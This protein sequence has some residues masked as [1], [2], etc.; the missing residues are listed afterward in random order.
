MCGIVGIFNTNGAPVSPAILRKMTDVMSHRGPDGEGFYVDSFVGLAHRRLA[1]L[2]L[3]SAG[4]QPM[5]TE[6]GSISISY[7]GEVYNFREIRAELEALGY[8]FRSNTDTEVVLNA[9]HKWG[10]E[11]VARFNGIFA[12]TTWDKRTQTLTLIRDRYGTKPLY[13]YQCGDTFLFASEI[14]SFLHYP[15][16]KVELD[17]EALFEYFTFQNIFTDRTLFKGVKVLR[18]GHILQISLGN[19]DIS[20]EEYWDFDF[21][22]VDDPPSFEEGVEELNRLFCQAVQRQLVSDVEIGS[23]L[24]GGIDSGAITAIA[25]NN[26][27]Y[28]K[29]FCIGFDLS[30]ASGLELGFDE[31]EKAEMISA[32][33]K[34]EHYEMVLKSGDMERCME[35]LVWYLEDPRVGQSYPNFY[36]AKLAGKFVKVVLAG[37]GGDELFG[38]YPWR[39]YRIAAST[40]FENYVDNYYLYWQRLVPNRVLRRIFSPV[41][42]EVKHVWTR[43]IFEGVLRKTKDRLEKP[44]DYVNYSL[45]LEAKTFLHGLLLVEDKLSM[46]HSLEARVPFLDNDLVDFAMGLPVNNKLRKLDEVLRIN[47]N[48]PGP[49]TKKYFEKTRDGKVIMKEALKRYVPEGIANQEKQGFA[50][51]DASWFRGESIEYVKRVILDK[52]AHIFDYLDYKAVRE[53]VFGHLEGRQNRRL[54]IW[55]LLNFEMWL[56]AFMT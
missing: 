31:R 18:P 25:A 52:R 39:Y 17:F 40:D 6:D 35:Q 55:S 4:H 7:N 22:E 38:G 2:D 9:F 48:E 46:A 33:Y 51:P 49:K 1:I 13:Y 14:K 56:R 37:T 44:E 43:D 47:E 12:F 19:K 53:L 15:D 21:K 26:F 5:I 34:T 16:F 54:F 20:D 42:D 29:T 8:G 24:S 23:Y 28:I 32:I 50:A 10:T 45:Y 27:P 41:W 30:S 11:S 3:T 36:A